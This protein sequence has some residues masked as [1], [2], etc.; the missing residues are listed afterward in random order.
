M[1][2][3]FKKI[4]DRRNDETNAIEIINKLLERK[5]I[6][7]DD[8]VEEVLSNNNINEIKDLI[9]K[10]YLKLPEEQ[11]EKITIYVLNTN[12][13]DDIYNI[14][15]S[16]KKCLNFKLKHT[17]LIIKY[18]IDKKDFKTLF[19][20]LERANSLTEEQ[21]TLIINSLINDDR[22]S[23][24]VVADNVRT[25]LTSNNF[26]DTHVSI[27]LDHAFKIKNDEYLFSLI[28]VLYNKIKDEDIYKIINHVFNTKDVGK[29]IK[30]LE[31]SNLVR[32]YRKEH[33]DFILNRIISMDNDN[34]FILFESLLFYLNKE[35]LTDNHIEKIIKVI[36]ELKNP[37]ALKNIIEILGHRLNT[38]PKVVTE[39]IF[40]ALKLEDSKCFV[41]I[42][43]KLPL[44]EK[45]ITVLIKKLSKRYELSALMKLL[46]KYGYNLSKDESDLIQPQFKDLAIAKFKDRYKIDKDLAIKLYDLTVNDSKDDVESLKE[47]FKVRKREFDIK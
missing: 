4:W 3:N 14:Y 20:I 43:E 5:I 40:G 38:N 41:S 6:T 23:I 21:I 7:Y 47:E 22:V 39:L 45:Q 37:K 9:N 17:S 16:I 19:K 44:N 24:N 46:E 15:L 25:L 30:L 18:F 27:L 35:Q 10:F 32:I 31:N 36:V 12:N 2:T 11:I 26:R 42:I 28:N 29:I 8:L 13:V 33:V 1:E 34:M